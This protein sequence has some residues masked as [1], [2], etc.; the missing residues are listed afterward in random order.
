MGIAQYEFDM[1][2]PADG[3]VE[4]DPEVLWE[5][6]LQAGRDALSSSGLHARDIACIGITNQRETTLVW[7]AQPQACVH[8]AIVWQDRRTAEFCEAMRG[9]QIGA[10]AAEA[11]VRRT[12]GLLIDPYFSGTKLAWILKSAPGLPAST[13][14]LK[15]GTVDTFLI[16]RLTNGQVHATDATNASRTLL[17]DIHAQT[18]SQAMLDYL[19]IPLHMLPEVRDSAGDFGIADAKWFGAPIPITGVAGDQQAALVGQACFEPGMSKSTYGTGCFVMTHTGGEPVASDNQLL[20]TVAYRVNGQVA[21]ALEGSIFVAGVAIKWLRD[22]LGLIDTAEETQAAFEQT[23]GDTSGVY[24]VPAFTGLGAPYWNPRAR[25]LLAGLTLDTTREQ[26]ITAFLQG[27]VYQTD[28]LLSAMTADGAPVDTLR[29]DGGMVTN[30]ALCQYLS[31]ILVLPVERPEDVETTAKGSA[32]LAGVGAGIYADV[33]AAAN[34]WQLQQ[35]F[36]SQMPDE[37]R[38]IRKREFAAASRRANLD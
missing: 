26:I 19:G 5:T 2:F 28:E 32:L 8:N 27:V 30:D 38:E 10:E 4:Q 12:T 14:H 29:V 20:T 11:F 25:G 9:D 23:G 21:Y 31:D 13:K 34:S 17:F 6:T 1:S 16:D 24:L 22:Q 15:F 37:T 18:Y 7:D 35:R 36:T 3:W 33:S